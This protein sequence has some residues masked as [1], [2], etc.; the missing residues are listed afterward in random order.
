MG[1]RRIVAERAS[2]ACMQKILRILLLAGPKIQP[3]VRSEVFRKSNGIFSGFLGALPHES[4]LAVRWPSRSR[5]VAALPRARRVV[6]LLCCCGVAQALLYMLHQVAGSSTCRRVGVVTR[7]GSGSCGFLWLALVVATV[8]SGGP[9]GGFRPASRRL[10]A[11]ARGGDKFCS[12]DDFCSGAMARLGG[13]HRLRPL[14]M[15]CCAVLVQCTACDDLSRRK[16]D[17]KKHRAPAASVCV[18]GRAL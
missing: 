3:E 4:H 11:P 14:P 5:H 15:P 8:A 9:G 2:V 18:S 17:L 16:A 6:L 1:R 7:A 12:C 10:L 13:S